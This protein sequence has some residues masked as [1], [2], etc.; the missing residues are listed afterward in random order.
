MK[1]EKIKGKTPNGGDYSELYYMNDKGEACEKSEA[2]NGILRECKKD[3]TL[4]MET[5]V[6]FGKK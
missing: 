2:T 5:F 3:G 1:V 4:V 6:T